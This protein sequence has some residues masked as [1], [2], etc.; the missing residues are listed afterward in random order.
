MLDESYRLLSVLQHDQSIAATRAAELQDYAMGIK[1]TKAE[2]EHALTHANAESA[3]LAKENENLGEL[4][5]I[6]SD[7]L[8]EGTETETWSEWVERRQNT[9]TTL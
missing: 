7:S 3:R 5:K 8:R 6:T 2:M 1:D 9:S 4:Y